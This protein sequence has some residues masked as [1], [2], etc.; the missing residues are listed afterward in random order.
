MTLSLNNKFFENCDKRYTFV[1]SIERPTL[2][3]FRVKARYLFLFFLE[4]IKKI[5]E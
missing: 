1:R 5:D 2:P 3:E 4:K